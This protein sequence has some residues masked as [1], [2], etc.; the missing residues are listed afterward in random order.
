M[1]QPELGSLPADTE[2][3][4]EQQSELQTKRGERGRGFSLVTSI[5]VNYYIITVIFNHCLNYATLIKYTRFSIVLR[6]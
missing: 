1:D 3:D 2:A 5:S 4:P 6:S